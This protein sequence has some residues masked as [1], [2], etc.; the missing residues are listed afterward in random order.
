LLFTFNLYRYTKSKKV[1][2]FMP[3]SNGHRGP[4]EAADTFG[5]VSMLDTLPDIHDKGRG[6]AGAG[7]AA[8]AEEEGIG[9]Q[10]AL[11]LGD[12]ETGGDSEAAGEGGAEG[13]EEGAALA[14]PSGEEAGSA[15]GIILEGDGE[16][17]P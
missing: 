8:P 7:A 14:L 9:E 1:G 3:Y 15:G 17:P 12:A 4:L 6:G 16:A 13:G 11:R 2:D 5:K 10:T